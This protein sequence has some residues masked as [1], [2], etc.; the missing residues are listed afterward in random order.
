MQR[1]N[2]VWGLEFGV[3][4]YQEKLLSATILPI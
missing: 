3:A 1:W 4:N 2:N